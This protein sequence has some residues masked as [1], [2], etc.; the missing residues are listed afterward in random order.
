MMLIFGFSTGSFTMQN[1]S[2]ILAPILKLLFPT[3]PQETMFR[4]IF[5]IRKSAHVTEYAILAILLIRAFM[6]QGI[7]QLKTFPSKAAGLAL[8]FAIAYAATDEFHQALTNTRQGSPIDVIID[9]IGA[10][11][12]LLI[13]WVIVKLRNRAIPKGSKTNN[14]YSLFQQ[15]H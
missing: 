8:A 10:A 2:R 11:I 14:S 13:V 12:G 15:V 9:T 6:K 5:W 4:I 1:T 7:L 3:M